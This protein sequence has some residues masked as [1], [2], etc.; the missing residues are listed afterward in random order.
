M[1]LARR[2]PCRRNGSLRKENGES[3]LDF[4]ENVSTH[5]RHPTTGN[6]SPKLVPTS[7]SVNLEGGERAYG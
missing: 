2:G 5:R 4:R 6:Q 1:K 7:S 3:R